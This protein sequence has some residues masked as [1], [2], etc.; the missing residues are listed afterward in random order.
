MRGSD[1]SIEKPSILYQKV[2]QKNGFVRDESF[3]P[4]GEKTRVAMI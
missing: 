4:R 2:D 3:A 1:R